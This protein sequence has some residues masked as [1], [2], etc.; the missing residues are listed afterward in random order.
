MKRDGLTLLETM[1]ALVILGLVALGFLEVFAG[2]SRVTLN[3]E[4]W[5][6][7]VAYAEDAM[8]QVKID[9]S[10]AWARPREDLGGGFRRL[11]EAVSWRDGVQLVTVEIS[12]PD[13]GQ[14]SLRRLVEVP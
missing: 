5:S 1:V 6:R 11:V 7:A 8:E 2:S 4:H 12:L 14:F 13:G 3:M 10:T 9:P